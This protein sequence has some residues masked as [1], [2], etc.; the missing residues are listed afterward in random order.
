MSLV[1]HTPGLPVEKRLPLPTFTIHILVIFL[2]KE[3]FAACRY[4][5]RL[6]LNLPLMSTWNV[7]TIPWCVPVTMHMG[8]GAHLIGLQIITEFSTPWRQPA[9][10]M[11]PPIVTPSAR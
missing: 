8:V 5:E 6:Y 4:A 10:E 2:L 9:V 11:L 1:L 3:R 7:G